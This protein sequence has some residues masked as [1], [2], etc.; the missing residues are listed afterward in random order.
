M[1]LN[2]SSFSLYAQVIE[3]LIATHFRQMMKWLFHVRSGTPSIEGYTDCAYAWMVCLI[4]ALASAAH[5][6]WYS[7]GES[8]GAFVFRQIAC[9][10]SL[11]TTI[12]DLLYNKKIEYIKPIEAPCRITHQH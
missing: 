6:Y 12:L 4:V 3:L 11:W 7:H 2:D 9:I 1:S 10:Y 8:N 5:A